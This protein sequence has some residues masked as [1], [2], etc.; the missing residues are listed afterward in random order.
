MKKEIFDLTT[1]TAGFISDIPTKIIE[2]NVNVFAEFLCTSTNNSIK[3]SLFQSCLQF[4]DMP[5]LHKKGRK[6]AKQNMGQQ[7]FYQ[8]YHKFIQKHV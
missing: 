7:A 8:L 2:E 4:S 5:L 1:K 6:D 3:P